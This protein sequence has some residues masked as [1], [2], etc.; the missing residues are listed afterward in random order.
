[1]WNELEIHPPE[2]DNVM[3]VE[4]IKQINA[5]QEELDYKPTKLQFKEV[6]IERTGYF[7]F[8]C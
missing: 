4:C 7:S 3:V 2:Y 5:Y 1:M 6:N 8:D